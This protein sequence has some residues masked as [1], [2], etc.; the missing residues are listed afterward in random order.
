MGTGELEISEVLRKL[1][2]AFIP[3]KDDNNCSGWECNPS[4][5]VRVLG[6][7]THECLGKAGRFHKGEK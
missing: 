7:I 5:G 4:V 1:I 2:H 3:G 6:I